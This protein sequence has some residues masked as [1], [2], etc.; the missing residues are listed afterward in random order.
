MYAL[1]SA[2]R[3]SGPTWRGPGYRVT[4]YRDLPLTAYFTAALERERFVCQ[5]VC[6]YDGFFWGFICA[7]ISL[8]YRYCNQI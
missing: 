4:E 6:L 5:N 7:A 3:A 8:I 1:E 2:R